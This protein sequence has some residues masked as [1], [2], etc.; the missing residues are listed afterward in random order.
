MRARENPKR[1]I[2]VKD[3]DDFPNASRPGVFVDPLSPEALSGFESPNVPSNCSAITARLGDELLRH[4]PLDRRL[5]A[6]PLLQAEA[7]YKIAGDQWNQFSQASLVL[8]AGLDAF[9]LTTFATLLARLA[10]QEIVTFRN[11][12]GNSRILS[13]PFDAEGSFR[14]LLAMALSTDASLADQPCAIEFDF[15]SSHLSPTDLPDHALRMTAQVS[16]AEILVRLASSTD[17]WDQAVLRLWLRY[18]DSLLMAAVLAPDTGWKTLPLFDSV[19]AQ[20]FY[21]IWCFLKLRL[22]FS[23]ITDEVSAVVLPI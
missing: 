17:L 6:E 1:A 4:L 16:N 10:G 12:N 23:N 21:N 8:E 18:F 7:T 19:D 14:S 13:L 2:S 5:N 11:V 20:Q 22:R 9:L 15:T 3:L